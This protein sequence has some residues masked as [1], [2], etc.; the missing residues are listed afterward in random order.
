MKK[1][2][3]E[4]YNPDSDLRW[5]VNKN[6]IFKPGDLVYH[7]RS[8][9]GAQPAVYTILGPWRA[10]I[11]RFSLGKTGN[12][13]LVYRHHDGQRIRVIE[14]RLAPW[15]SDYPKYKPLEFLEFPNIT[16]IKPNLYK[17]QLIEIKPMEMPKCNIFF[18]DYLR[19]N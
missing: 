3:D 5:P 2:K 13:Y 4:H 18:E 6:M 10:Q 12:H 8:I 14:D 9:I 17:N 11:P 15:E 7:T 1:F 16:Q 19:D